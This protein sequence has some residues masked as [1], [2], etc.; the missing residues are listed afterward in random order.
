MDYNIIWFILIA[1]LFTGFF[2]LEGFDYGVGMLMP[3]VSDREDDRSQVLSTIAPVWDGNEVWMI[4]AG[5]ATFAAFPHVYATMFSTFYLALFLML[6]ALILRGVAF[7][8]RHH[9]ESLVWQQ[10]WDKAIFI[11][12]ALPAL[13]WGVAMTDLL[14]GLPIGQDMVYQGTFFDLLS[15]A[16]I[17]GG[18]AFMSLFAFHGANFLTIKLEK[19]QLCDAAREIGTRCAMV[20]GVSLILLVVLIHLKV[21]LLLQPVALIL[22]VLALLAAVFG[23]M[24]TKARCGMRAFIST[25]LSIVF[26][27]VGLFLALFPRLMVSSLNPDWSLTI[28]NAASSE[29]TLSIM[30]VAAFCLVPVVLIYQGWTYWVFRHRIK[31]DGNHEY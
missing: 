15:P 3:F 31:A 7:E 14:I 8:L 28:T 24:S 22:L 11:G 21:N 20:A 26:V 30:T 6:I 5:G 10:V 16:S 17:V 1:V 4:T 9:H 29:Y 25:S 19:V 18:L 23:V 2:F 13:L 12:S 27:T